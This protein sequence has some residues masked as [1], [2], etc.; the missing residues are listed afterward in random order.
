M[1]LVHSSYF[2][3]TPLQRKIEDRPRGGRIEGIMMLPQCLRFVSSGPCWLHAVGPFTGIT[4]KD[5]IVEAIKC[6]NT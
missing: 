5:A 3:G 4:S 2:R 1:F 6:A